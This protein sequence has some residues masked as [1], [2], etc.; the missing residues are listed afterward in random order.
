MPRSEPL[1]TAAITAPPLVRCGAEM[2]G[3]GTALPATIVP[4]AVIAEQL[5]IDAEWIL[6]RTGIEERRSAQPGERLFESAAAAGVEP[7][8][9]AEVSPA[10]VDLIVLA[11]PS[12]EELMPAA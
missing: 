9:E 1:A 2:V 6:K 11:T 10:E 4:N 8:A 5:G 7:L 12:N 3:V